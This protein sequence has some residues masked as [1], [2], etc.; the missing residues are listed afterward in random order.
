MARGKTKVKQKKALKKRSQAKKQ[1]PSRSH[2]VSLLSVMGG[3]SHTPPLS[4]LS[5]ST[6]SKNNAAV[7]EEKKNSFMDVSDLSWE[8]EKVSKTVVEQPFDYY[9]VFDIEATCDNR[10]I[11]WDHGT[12]YLLPSIIVSCSH[13]FYRI[14]FYSC[15]VAHNQYS[16]LPPSVAQKSSSSPLSSS[17]PRHTRLTLSSIGT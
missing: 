3:G 11:E 14:R 6:K 15:P 5:N 12:S 1:E 8:L 2:R 17:M 13:M 4:G 7:M 9:A 10:E 16:S